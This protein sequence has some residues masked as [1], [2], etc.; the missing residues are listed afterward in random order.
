[1]RSPSETEALINILRQSASLRAASS[2][3]TLLKEGRIALFA[4]S[5]SSISR[6]GGARRGGRNRGFFHATQLGIF[7][8][9]WNVLCP[10]CGGVLNTGTTLKT[11][12]RA[13]YACSLCAAGYEPTLD[14]GS[15]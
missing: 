3:E 13:T 14:E 8:L 10:G 7:E 5:M 6:P 4:G 1:M 15:R 12:D 9:A 11:V 2:I